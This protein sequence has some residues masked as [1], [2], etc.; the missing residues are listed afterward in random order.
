MSSYKRIKNPWSR[1]SYG[2]S[3]VT[4][5]NCTCDNY[6]S[7][8]RDLWDIT[9]FFIH[10]TS[11]SRQTACFTCVLWRWLSSLLNLVGINFVSG[12]IG[13]GCTWR[14]ESSS[15]NRA[16]TQ[17]STCSGKKCVKCAMFTCMSPVKTKKSMLWKKNF[18]KLC[19]HTHISTTYR[20]RQKKVYQ[21]MIPLNTLN[22]YCLI[23]PI[24]E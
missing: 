15:C 2:I 18:I 19:W 4:L 20:V 9:H 7:N 12:H 23:S 5:L 3:D 21:N 14:G 16:S 10:F 1:S 11:P 8:W 17:S 22:I 13:Q 6:I 24:L